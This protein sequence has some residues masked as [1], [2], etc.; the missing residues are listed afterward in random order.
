LALSIDQLYQL[1]KLQRELA[2]MFRKEGID[3]VAADSAEVRAHGEFLREKANRLDVIAGILMGCQGNWDTVRPL[4]ES[5][6]VA[7]RSEF[8]RRKAAKAEVAA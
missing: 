2:D 5:G 4:L 6:H 3:C 1:E 7:L 8:E